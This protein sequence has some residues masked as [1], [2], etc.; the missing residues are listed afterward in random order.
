M[1]A[2]TSDPREVKTPP[3]KEK[4]HLLLREIKNEL[5]EQDMG[6][7]ELAKQVGVS[8]PHAVARMSGERSWAGCEREII[9]E[10]ADFLKV[11]VLQVYFW[12]GFLLPEDHYFTQDLTDRIKLSREQQQKDPYVG[13][14]LPSEKA[15]KATPLE[16][17]MYVVTLY[18]SLDAQILS[19]HAK[20]E[21]GPKSVKGKR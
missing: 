15:W 10:L 19:A 17:Q 8:Y 18:A 7:K 9:K 12:S 14:M 1:S 13:G 11:P 3:Y 21:T 16:V 4:S 20:K 2:Q 5:Y 6:I